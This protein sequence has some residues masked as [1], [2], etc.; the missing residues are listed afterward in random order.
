MGGLNLVKWFVGFAILIFALVFLLNGF[1]EQ[2][3]RINI[4][5][6]ARLA[7]V[8]FAIA[9]MA[10]SIQYFIKGLFPFW[11]L[12][13]RKY[14]GISYALVHLIHLGFLFVLQFC[15]HP[16]FEIAATTSLLGGGIAYIFTVLMLITSFEKFRNSLSSFV[17]I[18][19]HTIGGYWIWSIFMITYLK[20]VDTELSYLPMIVIM[21]L[22]IILRG[23]RF[24]RKLIQTTKH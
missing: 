2:S 9:F 16:V 21:V 15:F 17:W 12:S 3:L 23:F 8:Y 19:L 1:S 14:I 20:R 4:R 13:N 6:S 24:G 22:A 10:S 7:A 11:L 5:W 18:K